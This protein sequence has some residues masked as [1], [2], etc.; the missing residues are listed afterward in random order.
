MKIEDL[1]QQGLKV[2]VSH[3]R[4]YERVKA[5]AE[6]SAVI[7]QVSQFPLL[8]KREAGQVGLGGKDVLPR[9]GYSQM[10]VYDGDKEIAFASTTCSAK[11]MYSRKRA[12][13]ILLG[14]VAK[15][16]L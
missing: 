9:G 13:Q 5:W 3:R 16:L 1:K 14:R 2:F 12:N 8:T 15:Q 4:W 10:T 7:T 6:G 11:D